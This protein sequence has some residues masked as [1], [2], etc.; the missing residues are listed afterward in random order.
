MAL[1]KINKELQYLVLNTQVSFLL[2]IIFFISKLQ[3][4]ALG[5][6]F[7]TRIYHPNIDNCRYMNLNFLLWTPASNIQKSK[8]AIVANLLYINFNQTFIIQVLLS[9]CQ[10]L[11]YPN[12]GDPLVP[13][14]ASM[15]K[16][17]RNRYEAIAREWTRRY[18]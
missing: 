7:I 17:D 8:S 6:R 15:Y 3:L 12:Q 9:I 11:T 4:L 16:N 1:K 2:T 5:V 13:E 14:I 18:T 10:L